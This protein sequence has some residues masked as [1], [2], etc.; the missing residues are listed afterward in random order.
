MCFLGVCGWLLV[1][2]VLVTCVCVGYCLFAR[3]V[4]FL[5]VVIVACFGVYTWFV[6]TIV[7]GFWFLSC[8]VFGLCLRVVLL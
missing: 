1:A 7:C 5:S 2:S 4:G 8:G 6:F 3:R